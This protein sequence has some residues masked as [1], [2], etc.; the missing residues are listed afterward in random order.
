MKVRVPQLVALLRKVFD[1]NV[2]LQTNERYKVGLI[3]STDG[4][5]FHV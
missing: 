4:V 1:R 2:I 3:Q 5:L